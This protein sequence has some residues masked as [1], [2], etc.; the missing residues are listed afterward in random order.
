MT[1]GT[2][3]GT[4]VDGMNAIAAATGMDEMEAEIG[5]TTTGAIGGIEIGAGTVAPSETSTTAVRIDE[6]A[7]EITDEETVTIESASANRSP[8][9]P[10]KPK[11]P[12]LPLPPPQQPTPVSP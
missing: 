4:M 2:A 12:L 3:I 6:E 11:P 10:T 7:I 1:G 9:P 8:R 5:V